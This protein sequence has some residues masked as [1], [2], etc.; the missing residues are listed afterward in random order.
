MPVLMTVRLGAIPVEI[1]FMLM[2]R[3]VNVWMGVFEWLMRV[4]MLV[5][6]GQIV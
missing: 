5:T 3:V 6:L 1:L 4:L 2:M